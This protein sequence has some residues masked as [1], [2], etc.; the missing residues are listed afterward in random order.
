VSKEKDTVNGLGKSTLLDIVHYCL[1][2]DPDHGRGIFVPELKDVTFEIEFDIGGK[3]FVA[4]RSTTRGSRIVVEGD[5]SSWPI[6]PKLNSRSGEKEFTQDDWCEVLGALMFALPVG[7]S[8]LKFRPTFRSLLSYAMRRYSAY[9]NPFQHNPKQQPWD[10]QVNTAY[11]LGLTWEDAA[12]LQQI[13]EKERQLRSLRSASKSGVLEGVLGSRGELEARRL[14]LE[15]TVANRARELREFKVLPEYRE[16]ERKADELTDAIH[17]ALNRDTELKQLRRYYE[18]SLHAEKEP[19]G[20]RVV[21]LFHEA[22][23][24]LPGTAQRRL[25]QVEEFHSKVILNR[26][27][28]LEAEIVSL[29]ARINQLEVALRKHVDERT[30]LLKLLQEHRALDELTALQAAHQADVAEL[31]VVKARLESLIEVERGLSTTRVE[32]EQAIQQAQ[33]NYS[34]SEVARAKAIRQFNENSH[35]LYDAAGDLLID[36]TPNGFSFGI[37]IEGAGSTGREHMNIFC[38]DLMVAQLWAERPVSPR[39][40]F[41]DSTIFDGVDHRQVAS[42]L[43]LGASESARLGFQYITAINA[44][45]V[46]QSDFSRGFDLG[47]YVRLELTDD[48]PDGGLLGFRITSEEGGAPDSGDQVE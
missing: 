37:R 25:E 15:E 46:P 42:A 32:R 47:K 45:S 33:L 14:H 17:E 30:A 48:R 8:D 43:E 4:R 44:D 26:R 16:I 12:R 1:G 6:Q 39:F 11:L 34:D 31:S 3:V 5:T 28:F 22:E 40:L 18:T 24:D 36:V 27:A 19:E 7:D 13:R 41:H 20:Q 9:N 38:Y 10:E 35:R 23:I 29:Q 21:Q 2:S